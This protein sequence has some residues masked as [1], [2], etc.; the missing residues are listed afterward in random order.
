MP[1]RVRLGGES[2]PDPLDP[3]RRVLPVAADQRQVEH[4]DHGRP[5]GVLAIPGEHVDL[6]RQRVVDPQVAAV[7]QGGGDLQRAPFAPAAHDDRQRSDGPRVA[8]G[9]REVDAATVVRLRAGAPERPHRLDGRLEPVEPFP[10]GR[11]V[12]PV[13]RVLAFPPAGAQTAEGPPAAEHVEGGRGLGD[14]PGRPQGHRRDQ[15]AEPQ[16]RVQTREEA[17]GHP[18]LRDGLPGPV[19]LGDLDQVVHHARCRRTRPG[20]R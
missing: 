17:E 6:V 5:T 8:G 14:H 1:G 9:L 3:S 18:G 11:E 12:D 20:R 13:R 15:G 7:A 4:G 2:T 19:D 10:R 16:R